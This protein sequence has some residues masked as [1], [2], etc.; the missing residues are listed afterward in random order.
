LAS[1]QPKSESGGRFTNRETGS[2]FAPRAVDGNRRGA[3]ARPSDWELLLPASAGAADAPSQRGGPEADSWADEEVAQLQPAAEVTETAPLA[4]AAGALMGPVEFTDVAQFALPA[5]LKVKSA[6]EVK[7]AV[8]WPWESVI[9]SRT[10]VWPLQGERS[11]A[12]YS[13]AAGILTS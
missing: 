5:A 8:F 13:Q 7:S 11:T 2:L 6:H 10:T 12:P 3:A 9:N 4:P 1:R